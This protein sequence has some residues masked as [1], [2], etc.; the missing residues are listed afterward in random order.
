MSKW[1]M[2]EDD[3]SPS[4]QLAKTTPPGLP[5]L[6]GNGPAPVLPT[7]RGETPS[8]MDV[9]KNVQNLNVPIS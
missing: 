6:A 3:P 8:L 1:Q 5:R 9:L 4:V 7:D 2:I